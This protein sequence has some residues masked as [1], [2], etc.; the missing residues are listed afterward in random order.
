M[1]E[2]MSTQAGVKIISAAV[3][4]ENYA[5]PTYRLVLTD[6]FVRAREWSYSRQSPSFLSKA[7]SWHQRFLNTGA[8]LA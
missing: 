4:V 8:M 6:C 7:L 3:I 5:H 2:R 1:S